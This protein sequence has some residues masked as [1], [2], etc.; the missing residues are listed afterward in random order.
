MGFVCVC[1]SVLVGVG[2]GVVVPVVDV[3]DHYRAAIQKA[4]EAGSITPSPRS[5]AGRGVILERSVNARKEGGGEG[6]S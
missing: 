5:M 6:T 1:V 3:G 4:V 2:V